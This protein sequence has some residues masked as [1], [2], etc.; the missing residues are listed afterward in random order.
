MKGAII[1]CLNIKLCSSS[2][3]Y[4]VIQQGNACSLAADIGLHFHS[5]SSRS[6]ILDN[7]R[8]KKIKW[9]A[10]CNVISSVRHTI[11]T[12]SYQLYY[13]FCQYS[14]S[15]CYYYGH[16]GYHSGLR[17]LRANSSRSQLCWISIWNLSYGQL[18]GS[19]G[20]SITLLGGV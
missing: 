15:Y 4:S 19:T 18:R 5:A 10:V 12:S 17:W 3:L 20:C 7:N 6:M 8:V 16:F 2:D 11:N 1:G 9:D 14:D 13:A